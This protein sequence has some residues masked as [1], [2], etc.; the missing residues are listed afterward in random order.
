MG[1]CL[2]SADTNFDRGGARG[3]TSVEVSTWSKADTLRTVIAAGIVAS[4]L[5]AAFLLSGKEGTGANAAFSLLLG[6]ALGIT[7]ERGRFCFFCI[8]R[9]AIEDHDTTPFLS[10]LSAIAVGAVGYAILFG[11]FL[12]DTST[13]RLPPNAHIGPVSLILI[14]SGLVFGLGMALSG[15]CISGHLYRIGQG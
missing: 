15:A 7:L 13:D 11:Q 12:P 10:I 6:A 1:S 3:A 5:F 8:F 9:D 4:L 14:I 2:I